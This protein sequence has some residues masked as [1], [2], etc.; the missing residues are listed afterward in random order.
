M[1]DLDI[2]AE[3]AAEFLIRIGLYIGA[4][5]QFTCILA[6]IFLPEKLTDSNGS[7]GKNTDLSDQETWDSQSSASNRP[8]AHRMRK[9]DKKKRR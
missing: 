1:V 6:I 4:L 8:P 5:F 3:T 7:N 9:Q 2:P